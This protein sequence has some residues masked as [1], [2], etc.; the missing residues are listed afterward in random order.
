MKIIDISQKDK[1]LQIQAATL[2]VDAFKDNW[3]GAWPTIDSA[4]KEVNKSL[5]KGSLCRGAVDSDG[6]LLGWIGAI[7][8]TSGRRWEL[9]PL[10]VGNDHQ[11]QGIGR[12]LIADLENS[13]AGQGATTL[14][15]GTDDMTGMT[16]IGGV[17]LYP[18]VLEQLSNIRSLKMHPFEFYKKC[19]FSIV[20]VLPDASGYG[21]PDILM[22]KRI[23]K[24]CD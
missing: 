14:W 10:A 21:K 22:A 13:I 6:K 11:G 7:S 19:G 15:L 18:N 2:L 4:I 17:D 23:S 9:H 1:E 20:G 12:A 3:P 8:S 16:S 24:S 5:A